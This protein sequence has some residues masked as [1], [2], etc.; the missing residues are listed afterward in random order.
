M[1]RGQRDYLS[2]TLQTRTGYWCTRTYTMTHWITCMVLWTVS[3]K[4]W[5]RRWIFF[6]CFFRRSFSLR[7]SF[8]VRARERNT[9]V[10]IAA[11]A[12]ARTTMTIR[13]RCVGANFTAVLCWTKLEYLDFN[14]SSSL[15]PSSIFDDDN[16]TIYSPRLTR[17][18]KNVWGKKT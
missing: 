7:L 13:C 1:H 5:R 18:E 15:S 6:V 2:G 9:Y 14:M 17:T 3:T 8:P 11:R 4:Q 12:R 16:L 10:R